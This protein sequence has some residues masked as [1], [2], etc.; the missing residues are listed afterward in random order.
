MSQSSASTPAA[1]RRTFLDLPLLTKFGVV[2]GLFLAVTLALTALSVV[3]LLGLSRSAHETYVQNS[4]PMT[5]LLTAE[6]DFGNL[7]ARI[8]SLSEVPADQQ[9]A[10]VTDIKTKVD[11]VNAS[12]SAYLPGAQSQS[13][14][15]AIGQDL[16]TYLTLVSDK[17]TNYAAGVATTPEAA[18]AS[19]QAAASLN[20]LFAD[21]TKLQAEQTAQRDAAGSASA[22]QAVIMIVSGL[23]VALVLVLA[24]GLRVF[25]S[26]RRTVADVQVSIEAL[27]AGDLTRDPKVTT[28]DEIGQI[29]A[30]LG[31]AQ[32]ALRQVISRV[33]TT[34]SAVAASAEQLSARSHEI[35]SGA[36]GAA[37]QS[38]AVAA[39]AE[40]VSR[41][42]QTVAA[43]AEQMGSSIGE[44][45][46]NASQAA[47]VAAQA[48]DVAA[49]TN[50]QVAR[51][52]VSSQEIGAVVKTIT[53]IA[54]QTNLL[55][56]NAT[57]EAARAGE[58]GK[59]FAV[60]AGEVKDLAQE[61]AK[62]TEDIA[63]RVEAIQSETGGAVDAIGQIAAIVGQINDYQTTIAAAVEEQTVT[64]NEMSRNV[65]E[66]ATGSGEIASNITGIAGAAQASTDA[67]QLMGTG[68]ADLT[69]MA[70]SLR[71]EVSTFT[72]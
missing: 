52:G 13:N 59:G 45:A 44:I 69:Q 70:E 51:L 16:T 29:A 9:D 3:R 66:A 22:R 58:A 2:L 21:E 12:V 36:A 15:D 32:A 34:S 5:K 49:A 37:E 35:A 23:V 31:R 6:A 57:I 54:E 50:E 67:A 10:A 33:A 8:A 65:A 63:R 27:A 20:T 19:R 72:Y 11:A 56:L 55:A 24:L 46:Q 14:A 26:L 39:A 68:V 38:S 43:G 48:T 64:T 71:A 47:K 62:A 7:R 30:G 40:Q 17:L 1:R 61:T 28:A 53:Q 42:V 60:V 4:V 41:N 18:D 25:A